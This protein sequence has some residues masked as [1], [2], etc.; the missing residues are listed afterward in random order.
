MRCKETREYLVDFILD[1]LLPELQ[2]LINEHLTV[3]EECRG[4]AS[5]IEATVMGLENSI[6]FKPSSDVYRKIQDQ[7][8]VRRPIRTRILGLPRGLAYTFGAFLMGVILTKSI[9]TFTT[10]TTEPLRVEV[11]QE[12]SRKGPF[13]DTVEFYAVP[14]RNLARI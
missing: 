7:L 2:I 13:S 3:C 9:D 4:E 6:G 14:A 8:P 12:P 5:R 11:E 1:E 10:K